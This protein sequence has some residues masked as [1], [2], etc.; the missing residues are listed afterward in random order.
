[1]LELKT[2]TLTPIQ[3]N[4]RILYSKD[5]PEALVIDPAGE[6]ETVSAFLKSHNL[7]PVQIW[8]TH[9]HLDHCGGVADLK[10]EFPEVKLFAHAH[11]IEKDFRKR[12]ASIAAGYGMPEGIMKDCPEP[13]VYI[14]GAETLKFLDHDFQVLFTPGHSPGHVSFYQKEMQILLGGDALFAGSIGR[15]DFPSSN[16]ADLIAAITEKIFTLPNQ[17]KVLPGHGPF[18]TV[19]TERATNPFFR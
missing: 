1:M 8:L 2:L 14:E 19:A 15:T 9:S 6:S 5:R 7:T 12:V 3:Q 4:T 11:P 10:S 17:T 16:H 13:D 18:T